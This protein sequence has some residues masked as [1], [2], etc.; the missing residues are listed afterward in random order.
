M[1]KSEDKDIGGYEILGE[2]TA[3][4]DIMVAWCIEYNLPTKWEV[5]Q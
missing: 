5:R 2:D 1:V 3:V 4:D